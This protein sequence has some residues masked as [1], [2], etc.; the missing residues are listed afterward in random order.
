MEKIFVVLGQFQQCYEATPSSVY[1]LFTEEQA[2]EYHRTLTK[3]A[4]LDRDDPR[5]GS[6]AGYEIVELSAETGIRSLE[7]ARKNLAELKQRKEEEER[8]V[9]PQQPKSLCTMGDF[10]PK[11]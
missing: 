7:E 11:T 9:P 6:W 10:F 1:G 2:K 5:N 3:M 4:R 8:Y